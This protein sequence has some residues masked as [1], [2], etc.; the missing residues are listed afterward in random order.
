MLA[1]YQLLQRQN[2]FRRVNVRLD[3][4]FENLASGTWEIALDKAEG[5]LFVVFSIIS[6]KL[7]RTAS[8][9]LFAS[10]L[11]QISNYST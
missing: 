9:I 5:D 3:E 8:F 7:H 11:H 10:L 1:C 2:L 4:G 6:L